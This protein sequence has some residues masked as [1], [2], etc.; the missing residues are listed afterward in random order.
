MPPQCTGDIKS[1]NRK[2]KNRN[3]S[4][5]LK[6]LTGPFLVLAIGVSLSLMAFIFENIISI[7]ESHRRRRRRKLQQE[8]P[9]NNAIEVSPYIAQEETPTFILD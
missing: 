5:S 4:L 9:T 1:G 2:S 6:N 3:S 7:P 8:P